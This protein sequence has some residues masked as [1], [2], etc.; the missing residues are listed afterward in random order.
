MNYVNDLYI[1]A[2]NTWDDKATQ[3]RGEILPT[4]LQKINK[5]S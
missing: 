4:D 2:D 5:I 1:D 3:L